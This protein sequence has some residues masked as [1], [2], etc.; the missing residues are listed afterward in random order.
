M[1]GR[2]SVGPA[3]LQIVFDPKG[4]M[5]PFEN[6][7]LQSPLGALLVRWEQQFRVCNQHYRDKLKTYSALDHN[8][9]RR[10]E[11]YYKR[12]GPATDKNTAK[13]FSHKY[14]W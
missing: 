9:E 5:A 13:W 14:L 7:R 2:F 10:R 4:A 11:L 6:L 3:D 1:H 12:F 8:D